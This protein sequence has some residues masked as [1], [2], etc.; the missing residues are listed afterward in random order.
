MNILGK[1]WW[2]NKLTE[3]KKGD[4]FVVVSLDKVFYFQCVKVEAHKPQLCG[5]DSHTIVEDE[6][7]TYGGKA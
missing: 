1:S 3:M 4:K 2:F 7:V 5:M 6:I